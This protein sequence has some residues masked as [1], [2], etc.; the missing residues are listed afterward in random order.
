MS[1]ELYIQNIKK[2]DEKL[3]LSKPI[4]LDS[5]LG[6]TL[7]LNHKNPLVLHI[8]YDIEQNLVQIQS[9]ITTHFPKSRIGVQTIMN[10]LVGDL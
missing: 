7:I 6:V 2:L 9:H 4:E 8:S 5:S 3:G 1:T 10:E